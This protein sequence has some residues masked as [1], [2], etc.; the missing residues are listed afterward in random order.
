MVLGVNKQETRLL[1][2]IFN[3]LNDTL[4]YPKER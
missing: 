4:P 3:E 2:K 1:N